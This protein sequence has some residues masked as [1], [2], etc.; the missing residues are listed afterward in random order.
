MR[1]TKLRLF[2]LLFYFLAG[3]PSWAAL[4]A[5]TQ[6]EVRTTGSATNG[7][8]WV[9]G[10]TGTDFSQQ[11]AAQ[12][13]GT[14]LAVDAVV[15]TRVTS[16]THNFAAADVGNCINI[17]AGAGFTT[18]F[19]QVVSLTG[20]AANLDRSPA[21][22][23]V[24]GGTWAE[25]GGLLTIAAAN[26]PHVSGNTIW[27][28]SGT[29][30]LTTVVQTGAG[31]I[32]YQGYG[33]THGDSTRAT[34]TTATNSTNLFDVN[35]TTTGFTWRNLNFSNTAGTRGIGI[36]VTINFAETG[37]I[38]IDNCSFDGHSNAF[39][40]NGGIGT[41]VRGMMIR[42]TEI[43]N[44]TGDAIIGVGGNSIGTALYYG[45]Y[46]HDNTGAGFRSVGRGL[47][48]LQNSIFWNNG[49][50]GILFDDANA[51]AFLVMNN[52]VSG[53]NTSDGVRITFA[54]QIVSITNSILW[55]NGGWGVNAAG[56]LSNQESNSNAYGGNVSG[57]RTGFDASPSSSPDLSLAG[58]PFTNSAA[59]DF[60]LNGTAGGPL[61]T[62]GYPGQ[63]AIGGTGVS[64]IGPLNAGGGACS[65]ANY[66]GCGIR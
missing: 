12:F 61:K 46:S 6:W 7:G 59:N 56:Q 27:I 2:V 21:A 23:G 38:L 15:N 4:S 51:G 29:Y 13:S 18:G 1:S 17:T 33:T 39:N 40:G 24:T 25:G 11:N 44:S 64:S 58:D 3:P 9:S 28:R 37:A 35:S 53:E 54:G 10:A 5:N 52:V 49:T 55:N 32:V 31:R 63:L 42:N 34:I 20:A 36:V 26:T 43:K 60:T 50:Q 48:A 16:A 41:N 57:A 66:L 65:T 22:V 47:F 8:C 19:Y 14:D 30:T 45:L 62:G